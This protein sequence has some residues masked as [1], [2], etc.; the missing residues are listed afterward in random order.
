MQTIVWVLL[1]FVATANTLE[2]L[3]E[4]V[5]GLLQELCV[6][7]GYVAIVDIENSKEAFYAFGKVPFHIIDHLAHQPH[8]LTDHHVNN[9]AEQLCR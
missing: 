4:D 8:P 3:N 9:N 1:V 5:E 7:R 2:R 6:A